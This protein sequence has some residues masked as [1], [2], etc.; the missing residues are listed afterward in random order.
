M[1]KDRKKHNHAAV[2][3]PLR[4]ETMVTLGYSTVQV[5]NAFG[6]DR[7]TLQNKRRANAD[8][9]AAYQRGMQRRRS[10]VAEK[11]VPNSSPNIGDLVEMH[12]FQLLDDLKELKGL[13][14]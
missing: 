13:F 6:V 3:N 4:L 9:E 11:T 8:L 5:A 7:K 14:T 1:K 12:L 10:S 2:I